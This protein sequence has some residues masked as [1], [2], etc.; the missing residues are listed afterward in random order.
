MARSQIEVQT[1]FGPLLQ[2][3]QKIFRKSASAFLRRAEKGDHVITTVNGT[4]ESENVVK[5]DTS[6]IACGKV[7]EYYVLTQENFDESYDASSA[8]PIDIKEDTSEH[9]RSLHRQGYQEYKSKRQVLARQVSSDDMIWLLQGENDDAAYFMA[10]W[11]EKMRVEQGDYLVMQH[12]GTNT[13]IYRIEQNVF[14][15]TYEP[16]SQD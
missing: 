13:E 16:V 11:G 1:H 7:G 15:A 12:G 4:V 2:A 14:R 5:D 8:Q 10:P 6:W 9:I 3:D